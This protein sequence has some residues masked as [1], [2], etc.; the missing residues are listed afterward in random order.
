MEV[1]SI[2]IPSIL[3][4]L[5]LA[6]GVFIIIQN[7]TKKAFWYFGSGMIGGAFYIFGSIMSRLDF[8]PEIISFWVRFLFIPAEIATFL[9]LFA[10][11]E[12]ANEFELG[13]RPSGKIQSLLAFLNA[14]IL[15]ILVFTNIFVDYSSPVHVG[16]KYLEWDL[17]THE[18]YLLRTLFFV[19][20][21]LIPLVNFLIFFIKSRDKNVKKFSIVM[22]VAGTGLFMGTTF[23]SLQF[24]FRTRSTDLY[25]VPEYIQ[26]FFLLA[27]MLLMTWTILNP[28]FVIKEMLE[29]VHDFISSI[30][31]SIL[32]LLPYLGL[33]CLSFRYF[34]S[35]PLFLAILLG[36]SGLVILTHSTYEW[37]LEFIQGTIRQKKFVFP[38]I[39]PSDMNDALKNFSTPHQLKNCK[40]LKLEQVEKLARRKNISNIDALREIITEAIEYFKPKDKGNKRTAARL[41]YEILRMI[42]FEGATESQ[43]MWDL[44]F[45]VYTRSVEEKL[46]ENREPRFKLKDASEYSATSDRSFKR[47]KKEA[48]EMVRWKLEEE[49]K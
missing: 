31:Y 3:Y 49:E 2:L 1:L 40:L 37:V 29:V 28:K 4:L 32:L 15:F 41:K 9:W 43:I 34:E 21:T 6:L 46:S 39:L 33:T 22:L 30:G 38:T 19:I 5:F 11:F 42:A 48:V 13:I 8:S 36:I 14:V 20:K 27:S 24:Y 16:H 45:D 35:R 17:N 10:S 25:N 7:P 26:E 12:F 23:S 44:G 18:A 47:L